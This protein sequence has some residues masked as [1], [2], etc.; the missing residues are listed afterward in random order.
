MANAKAKSSVGSALVR[1]AD[2]LSN[3][4]PSPWRKVTDEASPLSRRFPATTSTSS[5]IRLYL[6][7]RFVGLRVEE[8]AMSFLSAALPIL[9]ASRR[10]MTA[11]E[12]ASIALDRRLIHSTG[13]T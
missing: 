4:L 1:T 13:K 2:L 5:A 7:D 3:G 12:I 10:E 11:D 8:A 9:K 6:G